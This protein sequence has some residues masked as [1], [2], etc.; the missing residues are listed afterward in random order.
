MLIHDD[1]FAW[2]GWGGPLKLGSGRC[3]LRI[4]DLR[5]G[6]RRGLTHLKP[7]VVIV[8][9]LPRRHRQDMSVRSCASH[10]STLITKAFDIDP[11]RMFWVEYYPESRYGV[12]NPRVIPESFVGVDF[13]WHES[14][15]I[16]PRWK[17]VKPP[18][19]DLLR[20]LV[21]ETP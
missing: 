18:L 6:G 1:L 10:L 19:L 13:T 4:F 21:A 8:S 20:Q 16:N 12:G 17:S 9:D 14:N 3:R 15:A 5:K 11:Q 7:V 2:D